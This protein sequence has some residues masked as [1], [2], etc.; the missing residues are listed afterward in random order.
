MDYLDKFKQITGYD[1]RSFFQSYVDFVNN[2]YDSIINYYQGGSMN[3]DAFQALSDLNKQISIIEPLF[4]LHETTLDNISMWEI[5]DM[6]SDIQTKVLTIMNSNKWLRSSKLDRTNSLQMKR[7]LRMGESFENVA[8]DLEDEDPDNDWVNIT[9]PQ[10]I[11]EEEYVDKEGS[12]NFYI[13]LKTVGNNNVETLVDVLVENNIEGKD[14]STSFVFDEN[15][16]QVVQY[17]ESLEQALDIILK[18]IAGCIPEY[19]DYGLPENYIGTTVNAIQYPT[20]FKSLMNMFQRD[21]RWKSCELLEVTR[22]EDSIFLTIKATAVT[23]QSYVVNVPIT[24]NSKI[25]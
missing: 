23:D 10:Y 11:I 1:I 12:N 21:D 6:F 24:N 3:G 14:F 20:I 25:L 13:N 4:K 8:S 22:Q 19:K 2:Y 16:I 17:K 9:I 18:S 15:D 5:L 7:Q